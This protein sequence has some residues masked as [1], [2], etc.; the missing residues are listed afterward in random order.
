MDA[1]FNDLF[2]DPEN[3]V[4]VGLI[5]PEQQKLLFGPQRNMT[6]ERQ[7]K[8]RLRGREYAKGLCLH[9]RCEM[10][11]ALE[12]RFSSLE[13]MVGIDDEVAFNG[14]HAVA[15]KITGDGNVLY[16]KLIAT[17]DEPLPVRFS[18]DGISTLTILVDFGDG[19]SV[20]DWLDIADARLVIAK[21]KP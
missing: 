19:S 1:R 2:T 14:M 15:L 7:S 20:C 9:S 3:S 13:C 21:D 17:S 10:Q 8:L 4:F 12:K 16:E 18:L 11:W 5:A 6:I